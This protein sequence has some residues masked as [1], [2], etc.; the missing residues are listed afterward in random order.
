MAQ[1]Y[2]CVSICLLLPAALQFFFGSTAFLLSISNIMGS[3][4]FSPIYSKNSL[5]YS[6][7]FAHNNP[8]FVSAAVMLMVSIFCMVL[9]TEIGVSFKQTMYSVTLLLVSLHDARSESFFPEITNPKNLCF[10]Y[11][12]CLGSRFHP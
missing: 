1:E 11:H 8:D 3:L 10:L 7:Y 12:L 5:S 6:I 2:F 4:T 9:F